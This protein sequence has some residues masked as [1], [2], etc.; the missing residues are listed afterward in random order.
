MRYKESLANLMLAL[1]D[2]DIASDIERNLVM[3]DSEL[4]EMFGPDLGSDVSQFGYPEELVIPWP[5]EELIFYG[6]GDLRRNQ[7]GYRTDGN[8]GEV[9]AP[10]DKTKYVIADVAANPFSIDN[11]GVYFSR[12]GAGD[13]S[14]LKIAPSLAV[15]FDV[16]ALW[17]RFYTIE[18]TNR[19]TDDSYDVTPQHRERIEKVVLGGLNDAEKQA[20]IKALGI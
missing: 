12:S 16:F 18:N 1:N 4:D 9:S 10:W 14:Y 8:T 3:A 13:W 17:V 20:F 5:F 15:L 7:V 19:I 6:L 11:S 2:A